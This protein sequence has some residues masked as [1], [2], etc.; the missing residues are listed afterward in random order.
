MQAIKL[1]I[2]HCWKQ[3]LLAAIAGF[4]LIGKSALAEP[5]FYSTEFE[6][7]W[8]AYRSVEASVEISP[9]AAALLHFDPNLESCA[10]VINHY[11]ELDRDIGELDRASLNE[12]ERCS[13][14]HLLSEIAETPSSPAPNWKSVARAFATDIPMETF[15]GMLSVQVTP[16]NPEIGALATALDNPIWTWKE[17]YLEIEEPDSAY[18][19]ITPIV[20]F[21]DKR[22]GKDKVLLEF[23]ETPKWGTLIYN[24]SVA[25]MKADR[26]YAIA[27]ITDFEIDKMLKSQERSDAPSTR[28]FP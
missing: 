3:L 8:R 23:F 16:Q 24:T 6:Q 26:G 10:D 5:F 17:G 11:D 1:M 18:F 7:D 21:K 27:F 25:L 13:N 2:D 15:P 12:F 4:A 19:A 20:W 28:E 9:Y 22:D 14:L